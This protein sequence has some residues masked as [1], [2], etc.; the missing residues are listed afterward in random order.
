MSPNEADS[1]AAGDAPGSGA[2]PHSEG[3][4]RSDARPTP[5]G[6]PDPLDELGQRVRAAQEAA[7]RILEEA[8]R[9]AR[10][11]A[12]DRARDR[13]PPSG[14][15]SPGGSDGRR[16]A[17]AQALVALME[18]GRALVPPE[19]RHALTELVRELLLLVR[20]LIDWY[21]ERLDERRR[22]PV[23]VEDIPIT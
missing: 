4:E 5:P 15:A 17:E 18:L 9:S 14:Y 22:A 3:P 11:A 21:L 19:L 7:E 23:E 20:A 2:G 1:H 6:G 16:G 13:P 10:Q 12:G 8:G